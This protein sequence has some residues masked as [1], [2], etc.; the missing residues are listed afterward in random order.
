MEKKQFS[1][2]GIS[3]N[4]QKA[5][6]DMGYEEATTIQSLAIPVIMSGKDV[7]GQAQTGTGKT[8]AFGIPAIELIDARVSRLTQVLILCPTRELAVQACDEIRKYAKYTEGIKTVP[9]Y[10]GQ[11]IDRQIKLLKAGAPIVVGTP[12]RIM[13]LMRRHVLKLNYIKMVVLDEADEM[14]NMG[15]KEDIETILKDVPEQRQTILFSATMSP[16]ILKITKQFLKEPEHIKTVHQQL[17]VPSIEQYYFEIPKG[18]KLEV[19]CNALDVYDPKRSIV[20]CNTKKQVEELLSEL[21]TRGYL[22]AALHGDMR[23]IARMQVL[24]AFK[25]G[26]VDVLIATDVAARGIDVEDIET[27][28]N[29]DIPQDEEYYVHRIGRTGRA[30]KA[31][32][33]YLFITGKNQLMALKQIQNFTGKKIAFKELPTSEDIIE[34][35]H[36]KILHDIKNELESGEKSKYSDVIDILMEQEYTS[37][38]IANALLNMLFKDKKKKEVKKDKRDTAEQTFK[39][40]KI[41]ISLREK[42]YDKKPKTFDKENKDEKRR[43]R[44]THSELEEMPAEEGM[45][46]LKINIGR[47]QKLQVNQLLS[48]VAERT[49]I[50]GKAIGK[51]DLGDRFS[52]FEVPFGDVKTVLKAM[53]NCKI[54]GLP[55]KTVLAR[56]KR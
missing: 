8:A 36:N 15:F 22:A 24:S 51:I 32:T 45:A 26:K 41:K 43:E 30:G 42:E 39:K 25:D 3:E 50:S 40:E 38:D 28:F 35:K 46:R 37:L 1:E 9:I 23:Q 54:K 16:A 7:I 34:R 18:Q 14:L 21:Q 5:V 17:T 31:G 4:I 33:A 12:G 55:T 10:G 20:F 44:R 11:P 19:L 29:Y 52:F 13:D 27:V 47:A 56:T 53:E 49:G 48:A 2:L 6:N